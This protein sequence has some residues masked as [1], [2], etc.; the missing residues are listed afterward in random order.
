MSRFWTWVACAAWCYPIA[1]IVLSAIALAPLGAFRMMNLQQAVWIQAGIST[2]AGLLL[3]RA[4]RWAGYVGTI[5]A[6]APAAFWLAFALGPRRIWIPW[7]GLAIS[8]SLLLPA[9]RRTRFSLPWL[10]AGLL[11]PAATLPFIAIA[12]QIPARLWF[13]AAAVILVA[14]LAARWRNP[15]LAPEALTWRPAVAGIAVSLVLASF[16]WWLPR[17]REQ[18]R[19]AGNAR[20]LAA[21]PRQQNL[22]YVTRFFQ[23]GVSF[24]AEGGAA[25]DS[26][27]A[28]DMLLRLPGYGVNSIALIPYGFSSREG[29]W[30]LRPA[31]AR[32]W[33][34]DQGIEILAAMAHNK[35]MKVL[36]KPHVWRGRTEELKNP[37]FRR[38]WFDQYRAFLAHYAKLAAKIHADLFCV[39]TELAAATAYEQEWRR[40]IAEVRTLYKGPLTYAA[41]HGPEFES[42]AFWDALDYIGIDNYYPLPDDY[43][44]ADMER[45]ITAVHEK[46]AKPVV[47]TEAGY[48]AV[49]NAHRAPWED[50]TEKPLS[51]AEQERCYRAL[52]DSFY[53]KDWFYGVYWWKVGTNGYGGPQNSSMT[54][55]RKPAMDLVRTFYLSG[56][57]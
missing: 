49:E 23:R 51:L 43:S 48:S 4:G 2:M 28:R 54:P 9:L 6:L 15:A 26:P 11:V 3:W 53:H 24:T 31:G 47:F 17:Y 55:W 35:G 45:R 40:I 32:S 18:A 8:M 44:T 22:P 27:A 21:I 16:S 1:W 37:D 36:L 33:E 20:L 56:K 19:Q 50:E 13:V 10:A 39:G 5:A 42:V 7:A 30:R 29:S 34:N 25:Y 38:E 46:F 41:N 12:R 14:F 57:R 52:L